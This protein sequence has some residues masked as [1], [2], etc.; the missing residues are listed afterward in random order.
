MKVD[1]SNVSSTEL[2][3]KVNLGWDEVSNFYQQTYRTLKKDF[4][5]PGFRPGKVPDTIFKRQQEGKIKY[6]FSNEVIDKTSVDALKEKEITDYL[7]ISLKN[8]EFDEDK[9][10]EYSLSVEVDPKIELPDYKRGFPAVKNGYVVSPEDVEAELEALREA[11]AEVETVTEG[12]ERGHFIDCDLQELDQSDIPVVG[13]KLDHKLIKIGDGVFGEAGSANLLGVKAG[14]KVIIRLSDKDAKETGYQ[15]TVHRVESHKLPELTDDFIKDNLKEV[16]NFAELKVQ[17]EKRIQDEWDKRAQSEFYGS[18]RDYLL[19]NTTVDVPPSRLKH[20][21]DAVIEDIREKNKSQDVNET[22]VREQYTELGKRE[23]RW[24]LIQR[25]IIRVENLK[26]SKEGVEDR[27]NKIA[28]QYATQYQLSHEAVLKYY[29]NSENRKKIESDLLEE[30][31]LDF[32]AQFVK[33]KKK[34]IQTKSLRNQSAE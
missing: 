24:F 29:Q 23:I 25:D 33:E 13:R 2:L 27:L 4:V 16:G 7:D 28:D 3:L 18:I 14:E 19:A 12:A 8:L 9:P 5:M 20:F 15:V 30:K 22:Q 26:L 17:I 6:E 32:L 11:Y 1:L 21:L 34:T 31:V 10:L